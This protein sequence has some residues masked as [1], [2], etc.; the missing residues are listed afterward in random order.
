MSARDDL[1][2]LVHDTVNDELTTLSAESAAYLRGLP[3]KA[4]MLA[5]HI[6]LLDIIADLLEQRA[7]E[8]DP[9]GLAQHIIDELPIDFDSEAHQEECQRDMAKAIASYKPGKEER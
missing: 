5:S 1:V 2:Q 8:V 7:S 4:E 6:R 3:R 9:L